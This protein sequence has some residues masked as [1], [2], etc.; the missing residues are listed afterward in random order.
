MTAALAA[1]GVATLVAGAI[2]MGTAGTVQADD[3][4]P[5][6]TPAQEAVYKTIEHPAVPA[7]YETVVIEEAWTESIEH[8]AVTEQRMTDPGQEAIEPTYGYKWWVYLGNSDVKPEFDAD[9]DNWHAPPG[10]PPAPNL[11]EGVEDGVVYSTSDGTGG[12]S[13]F[14]YEE[15][16]TDPGQE[17]VAPTYETVVVEEGWTEFIEHPEVTEQKLVSPAVPA[18][19]EQKLVTPAV[20]AGPPCEDDETPP[21]A[22]KDVCTNLNGVQP[23]VPKGYTEQDGICTEIE[24]L[25]TEALDVCSNIKGA[26]AAVPAGLEAQDGRCVRPAEEKP[27]EVVGPDEVLGTAEAVPTAVDAGLGG[28]AVT[29]TSTSSPL[30][31]GL[32][33]AGLVML[34]LAGAMQM[35][36]ARGAHQV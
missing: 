11:P 6:G 3:N 25:P 28:S 13:W 10:Q 15:V 17:Y 33:G 21:P 4:V 27:D 30:G 29:T 34:L 7:V 5:C 18:W 32:V 8:P 31:Q 22:V 24:V 19:T 16:V 12:G 26:Q 23:D 20:P 1:V 35:G 14:Y 2:V 36:R 9:D